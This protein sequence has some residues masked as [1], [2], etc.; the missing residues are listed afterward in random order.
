MVAYNQEIDAQQWVKTRSS[1]DSNESTFLVWTGKIYSFVPGE[2]RQLLFKII[3]MSV[4]RCILT[5]EGRWDFT[6]RELTYYLHPETDEILHKWENPWTG[7]TV[8]VMHVANSPVQGKFKGK[9]PVQVEAENTTFIFDIFPHYPNPLAED[10]QFIEYC[11]SPIYQA[12]ELFKITVPSADLVNSELTSVTE[13][14]LSWDRIG[15]WLPW[16]KMGTRPGYLIYSATGSKV[17]GFTELPPLL[18]EEI[19]T[20]VPLYKQA[21]NAFLEGEDMT[22]WLYFQKH[23]PAYLA[24]ETFPRPTPE[25]NS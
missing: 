4:S 2:K 5:A 22:S 25:E 8:S 14:Q 15:Q 7:E 20:R 16:M 1:L 6:S 17:G 19:N 18:Q 3:G 23:F 24:G 11:P 10:P 13:L 21:P 9:L 12:A